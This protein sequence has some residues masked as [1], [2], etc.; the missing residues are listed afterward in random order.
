MSV[1]LLRPGHAAVFLDDEPELDLAEGMPVVI[2]A[3]R[4][5]DNVDFRLTDGRTFTTTASSLATAPRAAI[6]PA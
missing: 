5:Q 4:D 3:V 2:T 1:E 6:H